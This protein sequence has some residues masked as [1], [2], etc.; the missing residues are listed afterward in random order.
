MAAKPPLP[1]RTLPVQPNNTTTLHDHA[2]Q[3]SNQEGFRN[4]T[5]T[6][7]QASNSVYSGG[8]NDPRASSTQSLGLV[9]SASDERRTLLIIY[10]HGFLGDETSFRSFPAHVHGLL[11]TALAPTHVVYTKIYP[12]YKSR[13]NISFATNDF[14]KWLANHESDTTDV[15]L[16][17]HSLGGILAAEVVLLP[18]DAAQSNELFRHRILGL[19]AFDTPYFG[20]HPGVVGTGIAS[21]F[22]T[23]AELA[24]A[25]LPDFAPFSEPSPVTSDPTYNPSYD[26]DMRLVNRKGKLERAWYFWNKHAGALSK[27]ASDYVSSHLEFGGCLADYI[28]LRRR[29][30]AIRALEDVNELMRPKAANDRLNKRVRFVN[31]YTASTGPVKRENVSASKAPDLLELPEEADAQHTLAQDKSGTSTPNSLSLTSTASPRLSLEEH[32]DDEVI[33]KDEVIAKDLETLGIGP[34]P[35][36]ISNELLPQPP[37]EAILTAQEQSQLLDEEDEK[38]GS[39]T[40]N[41]IREDHDGQKEQAEEKPAKKPKDRTFC[42]LPSRSSSTGQRDSMWIKVHMTGIDEV[43]AHTSMFKM[44][45][46]YIA[47]VQDTVNRVEQWV[48][49]DA[50]RRMILAEMDAETWE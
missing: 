34:Q 26:N 35:S 43:Q 9:K 45:E 2:D 11:S 16:A 24:E 22:R 6:I 12:R 27:A 32:R 15:I 25:A 42:M 4:P 13:K 50:T 10:I 46:T 29:Y 1:P 23:P 40:S 14:S 19:L 5:L 49:E 28:G 44:G 48:Q 8:L 38:L 39:A 20:M 33:T 31:Y 37:A 47:L 21:L 18:P 30:S 17:G 36:G 41:D 3:D 7:P